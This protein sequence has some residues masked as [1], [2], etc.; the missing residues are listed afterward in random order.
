MMNLQTFWNEV[1]SKKVFVDPFPLEKVESMLEKGAKIVE[2]GC[3]YG[4][5]LQLLHEAG[6][7]HLR[8][9]DFAPK[10]I[11]RGKELYPHLDLHAIGESGKIP[12]ESSSIDFVIL[13]TIMTCTPD[14]KEQSSIVEEMKRVLKPGG[15]L[16]LFDFLLCDHE[17]YKEKYRQGF[18]Q[19]GQWG[20]YETKEGILVRHHKTS[21]I[22]NLLKDFDIQWFEQ[23]NFKT[24][25]DNPARTFFCLAKN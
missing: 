16:Y 21:W 6:Y 22:M 11:E 4:R 3:G 9:Y 2:Y 1:G 23:F 15:L 24:M 7:S 8:G 12:V 18:E 13:S 19:F 25:N 17:R 5:I 10:M 20:L 14:E